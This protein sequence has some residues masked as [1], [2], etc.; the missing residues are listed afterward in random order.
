M[1][2][3]CY[4]MF[5]VLFYIIYIY[6]LYEDMIIGNILIKKYLIEKKIVNY[7]NKVYII[8]I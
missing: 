7:F 6:D 8:V 5:N 3:F 1:L 2:S 4:F